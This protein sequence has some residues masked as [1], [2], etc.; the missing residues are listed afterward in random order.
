MSMLPRK[1]AP[2]E[3]ATRGADRSPS[4]EPL[5][6]ISTR[7]LAVT[8]PCTSPWTTTVLANTDALMRAFGPI[9]STFCLSSILPSICPSMV[10]SSLP[11]SSPLMMTLLPMF[12]V[13]LS[14]CECR[15][16]STR[17]VVVSG[18]APGDGELAG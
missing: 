14:E 4:T 6:R 10:R 11:L 5:S 13:S 1:C 9:V 15:D 8:L 18:T 3:I 16:A 7:S 2:S 17:G 12:T